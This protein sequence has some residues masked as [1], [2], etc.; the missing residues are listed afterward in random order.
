MATGSALFD[1]AGLLDR[2]AIEDPHGYLASLRAHGPI[3]RVGET[4][5]HAVLDWA[6]ID[7]AL[8]READ[9][10]ANLT[11]VLIR[12]EDGAPSTFTFPRSASG[13]NDVIATA[14][15]PAHSIHRALVQPRLAARRIDVLESRL[16][17]WT[18]AAL[19]P[20]LA[21]GGGDAAP[22]TERIPALAL[23]HVLGLPEHDVGDFRRWAMTGGDMLAGAV[24]HDRLV[25]VAV[26]TG[27]M[28]AYL[29]DHLRRARPPGEVDGDGDGPLL[30]ALAGGVARGAIDESEALGIAVVLFGAAGES[31]AA[32][33]GSALH[34]LAT[35]PDL[36][37]KLR[38]EPSLIARFVEEVVRLEPP[39]KFHYRLVTRTCALA[40]VRLR[41]GDRL[42]LMWAAANRD[43]AVFDA[44]DELRLDRRH[45]KVHMGFGRG[46][47][48]CVGA[49]LA[50]LEARV[51]VEEMLLG[52]TGL[53]LDPSDAPVFASS[54]FVRRFEHL[55]LRADVAGTT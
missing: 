51:V 1:A 52:T 33:I 43:P 2:Q 20:W 11:G 21:A 23:A 17:S 19:A 12:G 29:T 25:A 13:P 37:T 28:V 39:F 42:M 30:A 47:H 46:P 40:G 16:R 41:E 49:P 7:E 3:V 27:R 53:E 31:T 5:I 4:G 26:E 34:V 18:R 38:D 48:F 14:D 24:T 50:R 44:P 6:L 36:A 55:P 45:T 22:L 35:R 54:I 15:E 9:F 10:S 8:Q 32:L